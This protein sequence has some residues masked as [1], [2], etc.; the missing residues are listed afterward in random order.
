[1]ATEAMLSEFDYFAPV[2]VQ[3]Q[4]LS[5][6]DEAINPSPAVSPGST[7]EFTIKGEPNVYRDLNNS[8]IVVKCKVTQGDG[9]NLPADTA[10]APVNLLFHSMFSSVSITVCGTRIDEKDDHYPYRAFI[11]SILTYGSD[12]LRTRAELAGWCLDTDATV[13]D[14]VLLAAAGG[15]QPNPA[16][17]ERNSW[18]GQSRTLTLVGHLHADLFNQN[19]N[20]PPNCPIDIKLSPVDSKFALQ[21]VAGSTFKLT[22]EGA[23]LYARSKAV[24][25]DL[26]LSHRAMLDRSD[27]LFPYTAVTVRVFNISAGST[28]TTIS[29]LFKAKLPKR[30]VVGLVS[31][32]RRS[33]AYELNPFKFENF[34]MT[35]MQ[36]RVGANA[37][38]SEALDMNYETNDYG[39]AYLN[40]LAALNMDTGNRT[41]ALPPKLWAAAYNLYAFK[42]VPGPIDDGPVESALTTANVSLKVKFAAALAVP[43]DVIIYSETMKL[44]TINKLNAALSV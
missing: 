25:P 11:E 10:V 42:L 14:R 35:Q 44:M 22:I 21:A 12:V 15:Q 18:V 27:F 33:G 4:I 7:V 38:P 6:Y 24:S 36:L 43:V 40:T 9:T 29:D 17:L 41:H 16:F 34:R 8:Y 13:M 30:I 20:I 2:P 31:H 5:E 1:M 37:I 26:I 19:L 23:R 32:A 3:A 39:R 28:E